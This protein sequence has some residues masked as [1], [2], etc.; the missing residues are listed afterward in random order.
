MTLTLTVEYSVR[1]LMAMGNRPQGTLFH[2]NTIS[3]AYDIPEKF[4]RK[5]IPQLTKAGI[6]IS[7]KGKGGGIALAKQA[8]QISLMDVITA[9]EGD[10][11]LNKC[12]FSATFCHRTPWCAVHNVWIEAQDQLKQF[13][14]SKSIKQL[15]EQTAINKIKLTA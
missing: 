6:L 2:I 1:V 4:L 7:Q 10:I 3:R 8:G 11:F 15:A 12:T 14:A 9:I 5:I 13:L